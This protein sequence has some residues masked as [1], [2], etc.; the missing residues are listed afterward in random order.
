MKRLFLLVLAVSG[1]V[2]AADSDAAAAAQASSRDAIAESEPAGKLPPGVVQRGT[3]ANEKLIK[4]AARGVG[5]VAATL[6]IRP[7]EKALPYVTQLPQGPPG[8]RTWRERWIVSNGGLSAAIDIHFAE[9]GAGGATWSIEVPKGDSAQK[10]YVAAAREF[11]R[12][13]QAGDVDRMIELTSERTV[14]QSDR[15]QVLESYRTYVVPRFKDATVTW[16]DTHAP[17]VD[18]TG[19]RG[20][21]VAGDA[22]G[23][24]SFSFFI[25]VVKED[26]RFVVVTLGR[27]DPDE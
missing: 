14:R 17:A 18:E 16:A 8:A 11:V 15:Q 2:Q 19:N 9:D 12:L 3:L 25:T 22:K 5:G 13:A 10:P 7:V 24:E 23:S 26:G 27:R 21:D 1:P 4:D 20:W 6:G